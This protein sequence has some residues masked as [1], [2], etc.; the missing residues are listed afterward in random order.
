MIALHK[1]WGLG[2][3]HYMFKTHFGYRSACGRLEA[4]E[5]RIYQGEP[6]EITCL[7]CKAYYERYN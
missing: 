4:Y 2:K 7:H 6:S 5:D 3:V 1:A